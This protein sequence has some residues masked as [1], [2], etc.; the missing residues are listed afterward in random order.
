MKK[1]RQKETEREKEQPSPEF[2]NFQ[3]LAR[4][5]VSVPKKEVEQEKERQEKDKPA[6]PR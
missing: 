3:N 4:R 1:E 2:Q 6:V 5:L